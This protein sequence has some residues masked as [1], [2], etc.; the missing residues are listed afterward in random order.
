MKNSFFMLMAVI[1]TL[2]IMVISAGAE[3]KDA[4]FVVS[5]CSGCHK[6]EKVCAQIGEKNP[7]QWA[8][9]VKRMAMKKEGISDADQK[10]IVSYLSGIKDKK[11]LCP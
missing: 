11:A 4:A 2:S 3:D 6:I 8:L 9:T 7:E 5:K 1:F 10:Q